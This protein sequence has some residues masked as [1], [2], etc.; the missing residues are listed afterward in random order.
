MIKIILKKEIN[1]LGKKNDEII[2]KSGYALNYL[3][4]NNYAVIA[5]KSEVKKKNE[6][7]KQKKEK[8]KFLIKKSNKYIKLLKN[9]NIIF[10]V[11]SKKS[12]KIFGSISKKDIKKK[13]EYNNIFI[14]D[15]NIYIKNK[16]IIKTGDYKIKIKFLKNLKTFFKIRVL[17]KN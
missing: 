10:Y 7:I 14:N 12:G 17:E 6:I 4:P 11:K 15:N 2:V 5:N 9:I 16:K 3:I 8:K 13:L 1:K